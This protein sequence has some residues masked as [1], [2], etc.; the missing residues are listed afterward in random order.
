VNR[1][2]RAVSIALFIQMSNVAFAQE[3]VP[4]PGQ[5]AGGGYHVQKKI[6]L[7]GDGSWDY[8]SI[9]GGS[10]RLF[11]GRSDRIMVVDMDNEKLVTEIGGMAG[12]HGVT[13]VPEF[14]K[15]FVTCGKENLARIFDL[16]TLKV[17]GQAKT[18]EKPDASLYDPSS[19][20]VF[21]F[22][23]GGTTATAI[24]AASGK[25][26]AQIE[27]GGSPEFG[28]ADGK[29]KVYVNLEDKSAIAVIDTRKLKLLSTWPL[30]PGDEPTGLAIDI[31]HRRL[32]S[33]CHN[34]LMVILDADTGKV[35]TTE[36]IGKGVD[37]VC[38][39]PESQN[40]F[41]SNG[42]G[43]LTVVHE[44]DP[45]TFAVLQNVQ[46]QVGARTMALDL[47]KQQIWLATA[48]PKETAD[49]Q[50]TQHR[51]RAYQPD[52]FTAIVVGK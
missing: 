47:Q 21:I 38:F 43:T 24:D 17:S 45:N 25:V 13:V 26:L 12:V 16:S 19:K 11:I 32:F 6:K 34:K 30:E 42:D 48:T 9:D 20:R 10:R 7:G 44:T 50:N 37:A 5:E 28:V 40:A 15:G 4:A 22:N 41:S 27:I 31:K 14:G 29:G 36:P 18:G 46:T 52:S 33:G 39:D 1:V 51:H 8:L 3:P 2:F 49:T 23:N 35:I